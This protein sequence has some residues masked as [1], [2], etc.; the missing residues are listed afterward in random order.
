MRVLFIFLDGV[1]LGSDNPEIN[2]FASADMPFLQSLLC[3]KRLLSKHAPIECER[4]SL[5]ALD[6]R[7]G[8]EGL[9]QSA[10]GQA[11]LLT[12]EN[13]P[14]KL[15]Y[16][17]GPK[18]NPEIAAFIKKDNLFQRLAESGKHTAFLNAYPPAYFQSIQ[19]GRRLYAAI[20]MAAASSG[21]ALRDQED[22][23]TGQALSADF[24]GSGWHTHLELNDTPIISPYQ[25]GERLTRLAQE[26]DFALFEYWLSDYAGH[27]QDMD[28]AQQLLITLDQVIHGLL[29]T[30]DDYTGLVLI[31]SDHGNI[32]D[33]STRRHTINEV[34]ALLIGTLETRRTFA[35]HVKTLIDVTPAILRLLTHPAV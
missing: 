3:G 23:N 4:A 35:S 15:G 27:S 29:E 1:G 33:L 22:L 16:H 11:T 7:L 32:E 5:L 12:G 8:I 30:W 13:I 14:A 31:T 21:V 9:P 20:P 18:P 28:Q 10:T 19:S 2:P 17:Y 24:T 34:P 26:Y 25:A 6:A